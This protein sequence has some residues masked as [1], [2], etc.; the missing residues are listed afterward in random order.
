MKLVV[1]V[2]ALRELR[3]ASEWYA[4][5]GAPEQGLRLMRLVDVRLREIARSPESFPRDPRRTWAR[6]ARIL[7]WPYTLVLAVHDETVVILAV[8]HVKRRPGYWAKRRPR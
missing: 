5:R 2:E 6:R 3:E 7:R 8:A 4:A 1:H